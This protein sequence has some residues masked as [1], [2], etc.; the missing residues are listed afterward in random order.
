MEMNPRVEACLTITVAWSKKSVDTVK[1]TVKGK[2]KQSEGEIII[3]FVATS[4]CIRYFAKSITKS[5]GQLLDS[6]LQAKREAL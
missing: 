2:K 6:F 3:L 5:C 1:Y 4:S